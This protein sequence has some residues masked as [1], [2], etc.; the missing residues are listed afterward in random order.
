MYVV[1]ELVVY[2][3]DVHVGMLLYVYVYVSFFLSVLS[4]T[5]KQN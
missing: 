1:C 2:V 3:T 5:L 4:K